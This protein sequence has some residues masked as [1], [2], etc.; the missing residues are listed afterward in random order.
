MRAG[1]ARTARARVNA[2]IVRICH[3]VDSTIA[4]PRLVNLLWMHR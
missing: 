2:D 4:Y 3:A 1:S